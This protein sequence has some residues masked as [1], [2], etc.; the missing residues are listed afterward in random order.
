MSTTPL[1]QQRVGLAL[2]W[3]KQ[4][5]RDFREESPYF[6]AKVALV[7]GYL[8]IVVATIVV[9]PPEPI[10]WV[11]RSRNVD[12]GLG[13]RTA[14]LVINQDAGD[15]RRVRLEVIGAAVNADGQRRAGVWRSEPFDLAEGEQLQ[16]QPEDVFDSD[17]RPPGA[18]EVLAL[19]QFRIL[20]LDGDAEFTGPVSVR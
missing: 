14:L 1:W 3:S 13:T 12:T 9:A 8:L 15:Q 4:R 2:Q 17:H 16:L 20:Q 10:E 11:V 19:D 6:Q 5:W 18:R 7:V